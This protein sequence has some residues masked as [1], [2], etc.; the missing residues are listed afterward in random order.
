MLFLDKLEDKRMS[1]DQEKQALAE[2]A[3]KNRKQRALLDDANREADM[4][5]AHMI[6]LADRMK[7][8]GP[9]AWRPEPS[10]LQQ[11]T[12]FCE[13]KFDG[14]K[15]KMQEAAET[16][17]DMDQRNQ[18]LN[19]LMKLEMDFRKINMELKS[20]GW[21]GG[22]SSSTG[23]ALLPPSAQTNYATVLP[24]ENAIS[25]RSPTTS[26]ICFAGQSPRKKVTGAGISAAAFAG[27]MPTPFPPTGLPSTPPPPRR[28]FVRP[29]T[30]QCS[31]AKIKSYREI[32]IVPP[33]FIMLQVGHIFSFS[34][35]FVKCKKINQYLHFIL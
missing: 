14:V 28:R 32:I 6:D 27:G 9:T 7:G 8:K 1:E 13:K 24:V 20:H 26:T 35:F 15:S 2:Q 23:P 30:L 5:A 3:A 16:N 21:N 18:I 29:K 25:Q 12:L 33:N 22:S 10:V 31:E 19:E 34:F 17:E 4:L 11:E